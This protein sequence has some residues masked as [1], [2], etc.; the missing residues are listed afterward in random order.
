VPVYVGAGS[1]QTCR[2]FKNNFIACWAILCFAWQ[3]QARKYG[4]AIVPREARRH[5]QVKAQGCKRPVFEDNSSTN[6]ERPNEKNRLNTPLKHDV[7]EVDEVPVASGGLTIKFVRKVCGNTFDDRDGLNQH[8]AGLHHPKRTV[9]ASDI[10]NGVFEGRM[11]FPKTKAEIVKSVKDNK[12]RPPAVTPEVIDTVK[13]MPD[14][15]YYNEAD[16]IYGIE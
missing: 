1:C 14:K 5:T 12:N 8:L 7:A 6:L 15:L 10:V 3:I 16:L 9:T 11:N 4:V 2:E 13:S